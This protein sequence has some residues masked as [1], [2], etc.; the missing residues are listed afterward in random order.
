MYPKQG[1]ANLSTSIDINLNLIDQFELTKLQNNNC[2]PLLG[3]VSDS[4]LSNLDPLIMQTDRSRQ[5]VPQAPESEEMSSSTSTEPEPSSPQREEDQHL[6]D[7]HCA[8]DSNSGTSTTANRPKVLLGVRNANNNL[9]ELLNMS[10]PKSL[11]NRVMKRNSEIEPGFSINAPCAGRPFQMFPK[12]HIKDP[13]KQYAYAVVEMKDFKTEIFEAEYPDPCKKKHSEEIV[14]E[15]LDI[16]LQK[17][18]NKVVSICIYT[19]YSPCLKRRDKKPG[20]MFQLIKKAYQWDSQWPGI[21]TTVFFKVPWGLCGPGIFNKQDVSSW[22][23][24]FSDLYPDVNWYQEICFTLDKKK[25]E[26]YK[27]ILSNENVK[28]RHKD[29]QEAFE[30]AYNDL[31]GLANSNVGFLK[32]QHMEHGLECIDS[33]KFPPDFPETIIETLRKTLI[34]WVD[35]SSLKKKITL[36]FNYAVVKLTIRDLGNSDFFQIYQVL[37]GAEVDLTPPPQR[38]LCSID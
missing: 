28:D 24:G 26:E 31:R 35:Y 33:L 25:I 10:V 12:H 21:M 32:S 37:P 11:Y 27:A 36:D 20:C 23:D 22:L 4:N 29:V 3:L 38:R 8:I 34:K 17:Y 30:S 7:H 5:Q 19:Q 2:Q 1:L 18:G 13:Y 6:E 16:F 9:K 15:K 14:I